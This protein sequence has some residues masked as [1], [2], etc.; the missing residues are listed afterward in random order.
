MVLLL[1]LSLH[2]SADSQKQVIGSRKDAGFFSNFCGVIN[3]LDWCIKNHKTPVVHW[4]EQSTLYYH[5]KGYNGAINN[6]WEYYFDPVS[7]LR[8][9]PED[10]VHTDYNTPDGN[11]LILYQTIPANIPD[12]ALRKK[13]NQEIIAPFIKVNDAVNKKVMDFYDK[14]MKGNY[15]IGIHLRGTDKC[16]ETTPVALEVVFDRANAMAKNIPNCQFFIATDED[17]LLESAKKGLHAKV[18]YYNSHR[19]ANKN[20]L[21]YAQT[22]KAQLGEEVLIEVLLL[23]KCNKFIHTCSNVSTA[24]LLFNP[25]LENCVLSN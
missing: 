22:N 15:T 11:C 16:Y 13:I 2:S 10:N 24:V 21:H 6:V 5:A 8:Y 9:S 17:A 1:P 12:S 19:S 25:A 20:P 23:A 4:A 14:K 7:H 3:N 18:I